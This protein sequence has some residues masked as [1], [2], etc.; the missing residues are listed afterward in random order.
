M[1]VTAPIDDHTA[2]IAAACCNPS[3]SAVNMR[4]CFL[5]VIRITNTYFP[6]LSI[7]MR[8]NNT[9]ITTKVN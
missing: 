5:R 9:D 1:A 3:P 2:L 6:R 4:H 7:Q 8:A